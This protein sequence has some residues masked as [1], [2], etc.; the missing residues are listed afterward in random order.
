MSHPSA[1]DVGRPAL[2]HLSAEFFVWLWYAS[3]RDGGSMPHG[4]GIVDVW[5]ED[6]LSFRTP[7]EDKVRAVMTGENAA[8]SREARAALASGKVVRDL[9]VH[10]RNEER[11]YTLVLRG[12]HLDLAGLKLPPHAKD[13]EEELLYERMFL[14]EDVYAVLKS[15]YRRFA[16]ERVSAAWSAA[17]LPAIRRWAE[18]APA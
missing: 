6:R 4:D 9:Q 14:Y 12:V 10:L 13:G 18:G 8:A 3:E 5:V 16:E 15:L 1:V 11:E 7:D 17:T 2:P